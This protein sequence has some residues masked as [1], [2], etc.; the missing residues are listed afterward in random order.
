MEWA[1][2]TARARSQDWKSLEAGARAC[3]D[4]DVG[5]GGASVKKSEV[6]SV[7]EVETGWA[8]LGTGTTSTWRRKS[9]SAEVAVR[10]NTRLDLGEQRETEAHLSCPTSP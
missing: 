2:G 3:C 1:K 9:C 4:D 7:D 8:L 10:Q 6:G 5:V